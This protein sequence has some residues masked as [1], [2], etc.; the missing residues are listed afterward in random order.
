MSSILTATKNT[1]EEL[2]RSTEVPMAGAYYGACREKN[3]KEWNYFVFN[4]KK[5]DKASNRV[6]YQTF[7]QVHVV[8][9]GR[10]ET[11]QNFTKSAHRTE[12]RST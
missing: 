4:R 6:D 9:E 10:T 2:A 3:L 11:W 8:H 7:Y 12:T 5:T 1:L